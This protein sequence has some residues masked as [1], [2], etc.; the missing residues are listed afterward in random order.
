MSVKTSFNKVV[1]SHE[2]LIIGFLVGIIAGVG[3]MQ[4]VS[5]HVKSE[6]WLSAISICDKRADN[7]KTVS[8]SLT[9]KLT[10]VVCKD[11][12]VFDNF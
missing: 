5:V 8:F 9:G 3:L 4:L 12:R 11:D 7:V 10:K 6:K 1:R 2:A